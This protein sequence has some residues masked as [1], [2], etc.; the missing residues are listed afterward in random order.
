MSVIKGDITADV[1]NTT[2][3]TLRLLGINHSYKGYAY[4]ICAIFL[5]INNPDILTNICKGLYIEIAC[6]FDTSAF[7]AE[8]NIRTIKNHLWE[9]GDKAVLH[10]IFGDLYCCKAPTNAAFIDALSYYVMKTL[11]NRQ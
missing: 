9:C 10:E 1:L 3:Q 4:L 8:R 2:R 6:Q 11:S 5:V 7:C